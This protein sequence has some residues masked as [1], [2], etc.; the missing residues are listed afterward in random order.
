MSDK[1]VEIVE[2][3]YTVEPEGKACKYCGLGEMWDVIGPDG[4]ALGTSFGD[5]ESAE[6]YATDMDSAYKAALYRGRA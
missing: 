1:P 4:V 6:D 3:Y 5:K 2:R